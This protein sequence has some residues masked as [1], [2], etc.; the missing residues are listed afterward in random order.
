MTATASPGFSLMQEEISY[1]AGQEIP[2]VI[3]NIMRGGPGLGNIGAE[4]ADYFQATKGGG[5]GDFRSIVMAPNSVQEMA[6]HIFTLFNLTD[7]YR[8][9]G[10]LL[11]DGYLGQ[12]KED[13]VF[14]DSNVK[15]IDKSSWT[16]NGDLE[17]RTRHTIKSLRLKNDDLEK[18]QQNLK[19]KFDEIEKN[20]VRFEEYLTDDAEIVIVSYGIVSRIAEEIIDSARKEGKKI[21]LFRPITLWPFAYKKLEELS[22]NVKNILTIELSNGQMVEDVRLAVNGNCPVD[23]YGRGGGNI[24]T[25]KELIEKIREI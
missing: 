7:K 1:I 6:E 23:F 10:I 16:A 3:A 9:P 2:V 19:R 4:Q 20:E 8:T 11:A 25:K 17:N 15:K 13:L 18:H 24:P 5:H 21:G 12:M 22:K 14:P